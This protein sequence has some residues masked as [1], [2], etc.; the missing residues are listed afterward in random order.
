MP[1]DPES[2]RYRKFLAI[3]MFFALMWLP[4]VMLVAAIISVTGQGGR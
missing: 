4:L 1:T 3:L 2:I